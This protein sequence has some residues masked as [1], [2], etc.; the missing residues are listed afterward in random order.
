MKE[1]PESRS[2]PGTAFDWKPADRHSMTDHPQHQVRIL[3][4]DEELRPLVPAWNDATIHPQAHPRLFLD[5]CTADDVIQ[6]PHVPVI[7]NPDGSI[8][9]MM[10]SRLE[11]SKLVRAGRYL[12]LPQPMARTIV[13]PFDGI[14]G[15]HP[16]E[17][18]PLLLDALL[19]SIDGGEAEVVELPL[20]PLDDPIRLAL[21]DHDDPRFSKATPTNVAHWH[22]DIAPSFDEQLLSLGKSTRGTLRNNLNKF[23]R[24]FD[25]RHEIQHHDSTTDLDELLSSSEVIARQSYHRGLDVGFSVSKRERAIYEA[26]YEMGAMWARTL[27]IDGRPAAFLHAFLWKR[28][29]FGTYMGFDREIS[30]LPLGTILLFETLKELCENDSVDTWDFGPGEADYKTRLCSRRVEEEQRTIFASTLRARR[31]R[32]QTGFFSSVE[33]TLRKGIESLGL[34]QKLKTAL[35]NR[36]RTRQPEDH[37]EAE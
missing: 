26:A 24:E 18:A 15:T 4:S 19:E 27:V 17:T 8:R 13:V 20:M 34:D 12:P 22:I 2:H 32:M 28:T 23:H 3:R 37:D 36:A 16:S 35:R 29:L 33:S 5:L 1:E 9:G 30:R 14:I 21:L 7:T 25:G 11:H 6:R 10:T 31:I